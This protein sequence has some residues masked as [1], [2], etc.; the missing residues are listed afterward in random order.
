MN[1]RKCVGKTQTL[2]AKFPQGLLYGF[3]DSRILFFSDISESILR[4]L[5]YLMGLAGKKDPLIVRR[6][7]FCYVCRK[8]S[9]EFLWLMV[10]YRPYAFRAQIR[11]RN[12]ELKKLDEFD[13]DDYPEDAMIGTPLNQNDYDGSGL[14]QLFHILFFALV[15][16]ETSKWYLCW[17]S[18]F[19]VPL[20]VSFIVFSLHLF[21]YCRWPY[22]WTV[23]QQKICNW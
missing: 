3:M 2:F 23:V 5:A 18:S 20:I 15:L 6:K 19:I 11:R 17:S 21:L 4:K 1:S 12:E 10:E 22:E 16:Y 7:Y 8:C 9:N 13:D 14:S